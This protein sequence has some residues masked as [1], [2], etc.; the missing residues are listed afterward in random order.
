LTFG[1]TIHKFV[2]SISSGETAGPFA[3]TSR[4]LLLAPCGEIQGTG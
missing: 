4:M 1:A 2:S 3:C